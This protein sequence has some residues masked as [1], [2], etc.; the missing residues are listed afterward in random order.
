[1]FFRHCAS[2]F[3]VIHKA[4]FEAIYRQLWE[5]CDP[6]DVSPCV[7]DSVQL[8]IL[9]LVFALGCQFSGSLEPDDKSAVADQFYQRSRKLLPLDAIDSISLPT[10]QSLLLTAIYL[11]STQYSNRCWNTVG[12]AIRAAQSLG[13]HLDQRSSE[14]NGPSTKEMRRRIWHVCVSLD[15]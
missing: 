15:R 4:S 11:Q 3:P 14:S 12:V 9:N 6:E 5:P 13:L 7:E 10:I 1:M 8:S 2:V